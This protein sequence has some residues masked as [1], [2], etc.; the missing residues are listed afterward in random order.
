[1]NIYIWQ[2][3]AANIQSIA[4]SYGYNYGED[5]RVYN[6]DVTVDNFEDILKYLI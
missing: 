1:M 4:V 2:G 3:L 5:I 6:S